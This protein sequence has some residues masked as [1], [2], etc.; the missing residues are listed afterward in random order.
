[1][2]TRSYIAIGLALSFALILAIPVLA[3][4]WAVITLDEL[5]SNVV[6]GKQLTVGFTVLQ[7]GKTPMTNLEPTVTVKSPSEE[8]I[9]FNAE[10]EG[11][12]GHYT[13]TLLFPDEGEWEW[14]IQ[15]FT[16]DQPM[17]VLTV[18]APGVA[19]ASD[20]VKT[21]PISTGISSLLIF[22]VLALGIGLISLVIAFHRR[23]RLAAA[24]AA[25]CL[26]IGVALFLAGA[27]RVS[28]LKAENAPSLDMSVNSAPSQVEFGRQLFV[29]KGCV[30]C[31]MNS[32]IP[33][34]MKG[35]FTVPIGTNLSNFSANPEVL[36]MRLKDPASVK[37]DAQMPNLDLTKV[38]IEAL[39]AFINSK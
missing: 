33:Q 39:V 25:L 17:P 30:T 21:E 38:E 27:G 36:F 28:G 3:G 8:E 31:H 19:T 5:P 20:S 10:A 12:A 37:S 6:A 29:A 2:V 1:M 35:D 11:K 13:A 32:K 4:G 24:L 23:S 14:S 34:S 9:I 16:M 18:A 26:F 22:R 7:H 15:A